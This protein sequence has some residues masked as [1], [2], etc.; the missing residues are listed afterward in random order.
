MYPASE[1]DPLVRLMDNPRLT[2]SWTSLFIDLTLKLFK[3]GT[4]QFYPPGHLP[5]LASRKLFFLVTRW[6]SV[7]VH[8]CF[9]LSLS[10]VSAVMSPGCG[11]L[12]CH[13][14]PLLS[15]CDQAP[16]THCV[17]E[18]HHQCSWARCQSSRSFKALLSA[19]FVFISRREKDC[20]AGKHFQSHR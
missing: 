6:W 2:F 4:W 7:L 12:W 20:W 11:W 14:N 8:S 15:A 16:A 1:G 19:V 3:N 10:W 13:H 5:C 17:N 9:D 18:S